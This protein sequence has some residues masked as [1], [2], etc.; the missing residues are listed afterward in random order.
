MCRLAEEQP[1]DARPLHRVHL[2]EQRRT[3]EPAGD[4]VG[5]R[6]EEEASDPG[7]AAHSKDDKIHALGVA[8]DGLRH[9]VV[10]DYLGLCCGL[11]VDLHRPAQ[12]LLG[13][14]PFPCIGP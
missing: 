2:G 1:F 8:D 3:V 7:L 6:A 9:V 11:G 13:A 14:P 5:Q 4:L 12:C 10:G